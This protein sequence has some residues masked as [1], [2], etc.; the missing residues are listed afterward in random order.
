MRPQILKWTHYVRWLVCL[1][2]IVYAACLKQPPRGIVW[3]PTWCSRNLCTLIM[4]YLTDQ[5]MEAWG[6]IPTLSG[7]EYCFPY[8]LIK[9]THMHL[10]HTSYKSWEPSTRLLWGT[11]LPSLLCK[12]SY[13]SFPCSPYSVEQILYWGKTQMLNIILYSFQI[14]KKRGEPWKRKEF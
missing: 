10:E 6:A 9:L 11:D 5:F 4:L 8:T 7:S 1:I 2:H 14:I 13:R 12:V 3:S